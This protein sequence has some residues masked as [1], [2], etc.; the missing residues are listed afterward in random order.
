MARSGKWEGEKICVEEEF[1]CDNTLQCMGG[2]DEN[3]CDMEYFTK[4]IFKPS[5]RFVCKKTFKYLS[6]PYSNVE[7][8]LKVTAASATLTTSSTTAPTTDPTNVCV[9]DQ[10]D[11]S[12]VVDDY[13]YSYDDDIFG[14]T[15]APTTVSVDEDYN[16]SYDDDIFGPTTDPTTDP[17]TVSV[18]DDYTYSYDDDI[19]GRKRRRRKARDPGASHTDSYLPDLLDSTGLPMSAEI[20]NL[21]EDDLQM[22]EE[23]CV[24]EAL[25]KY[26]L[27]K[28][29][30]DD[31]EESQRLVPSTESWR[32]VSYLE[33][34][35]ATLPAD[36]VGQARGSSSQTIVPIVT[37]KDRKQTW[38]KA[39]DCDNHSGDHVF[40]DEEGE[41][42]YVRTN[43]DVRVLYDKRPARMSGMSLL[44]FACEYIV[45]HPSRKGF[46][47][48]TSSIDEDSQVGADSESLVAGTDIAA[49][50]TMMLS[51]GKVMKRRQD[52]RAVPL[53]LHSGTVSRH[54]N[55]VLLSP[56]RRL[57][58]VTGDQEEEE[59]DDQKK[60]RLEIFPF[61][62]IPFDDDD[63]DEH[64]S[65]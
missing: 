46:E 54:G 60:R 14:P 7:E 31:E 42:T 18:D 59:T 43:T 20:T 49:P 28:E 52:G 17:A 63:E 29:D 13:D 37:S 11:P 39:Q 4:K 2:E 38:R 36:K 12:C 8:P 16:Y 61:S 34:V 40:Q 22:P 21:S 10:Y 53:L 48:A 51:D 64:A 15:T 6:E 9:D 44:Q 27:S 56:W 55:Q 26:L 3:A 62:M 32:E 33:F 30:C 35:N 23:G 1:I 47:K 65:N 5:E 50:E 58:E 19:F 41:S 57:E 25:E 24:S 45:L